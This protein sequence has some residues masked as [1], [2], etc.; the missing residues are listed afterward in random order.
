[1]VNTVLRNISF[2]AFGFAAL[3]LA[4]LASMKSLFSSDPVG[5]VVQVLAVGLML[6]ARITFGRRS[7][8]A[9]ANPTQGGLVTSGP[10]RF[11][12]HPI[13]AAVT[14]FAWAGALS[15]PS[16]V[17]IAVAIIIT[18]SLLMR[19]LLEEQL[20][21]VAYP[22]YKEYSKKVKRLIPFLF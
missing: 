22:E 17:T 19:M 2:V 18:L 1:M 10:Y 9:G 20:V 12:R 5:I 14:Y 3:G 15:H 6:W 4:L 11:I 8:H 13:Y 21:I 16:K 7:Y